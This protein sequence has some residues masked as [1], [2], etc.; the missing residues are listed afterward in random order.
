MPRPKSLIATMAWTFAGRAHA[1][2]NNKN[3]SLSK[4]ERRLTIT[5][6]GDEHHYCIACAK[7]FLVK[8]IERLQVLL[9]QADTA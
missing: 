7:S 1:C 2:R 6:D 3:H 4:G 9:V 8:D 5:E